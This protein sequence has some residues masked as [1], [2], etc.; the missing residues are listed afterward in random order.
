ME[1]AVTLVAPPGQPQNFALS[2]TPGSLD[3]S[4][5]WDAVGGASSYKLRWRESGGSFESG[6]AATVTGTSAAITA[7]GY[8]SWQVRVQGCNEAGCGPE[9]GGTV[10]VVP[11]PLNLPQNFA[12]SVE[13]GE[14]NLSARWDEVEGTTFYRLRWRQAGGEFTD[15][16]TTT[17]TDTEA[18][19]TVSTYGEWEVRLQACNQAGCVPE[20]DGA[21]DEAPEVRLKLE[22]VRESQGQSRASA[23]AETSDIGPADSKTSYTVGWHRTE[24]DAPAQSQPDAARQARAAGGTSGA[25]SQGANG[26][27]DTTPPVLLRGEIDGDTTTV[28]FSEDLDENYRGGHFRMTVSHGNGWVNF[29]VTPS[30]VSI[31]GN[32]VT[33][34][35]VL[36][37]GP[38]IDRV[39]A[40]RGVKV[41]YYTHDTYASNDR[42]LRDLAGN[43]V[44]TPHRS[45]SGAFP[46]TRTIRLRN[47]TQPPALQR[48]TAHL[49]RLTLTFD[50][51]LDRNSVPAADAFT[52]TVNGSEVSLAS[53]EPVSVSGSTVTLFL[54][55]A[56]ASTDAVTVSYTKPS[57][58]PLRGVDGAVRS[59]SSYPTNLVGVTPSVSGV[60]LTSDAGDDDTYA[61]GDTIRVTLTFSEAV[62]VDTT[63]GTPR[64][65]IKMAP[66]SGEKWADY[67]GGS[68]TTT[69]TFD[70]T[71]VKGDIS[72]D[73]V[74]VLT[75]TLELNGGTI[76]STASRTDALLGHVGLAHNSDHMVD[77]QQGAPGVTGIAI[78]SDP[79]DDDTYALGDTIQV[80]ATF[81]EAM[82]VDTTGGTPRLKIKM[83]PTSGEK[84][85]DYS[86]GSGTTTLT[87]DYT[88][89]KPNT[90]TGGIAVLAN[91]LELNGG[92]IRSTA[93]QTDARLGHVGL[94]HNADHKVDWQQGLPVSPVWRSPLTRVMTTATHSA[95]PSR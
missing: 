34:V 50:E 43:V 52:V 31:E 90:S 65:K 38:R 25:T 49:D 42:W 67:S 11:A 22:S 28:Y 60:E 94:A 40:G 87:F 66:T 76:R 26:A 12:V 59:F 7:S 89:V 9:T 85:A 61:L 79:G 41:Y 71:V 18:T 68:G 88:V 51:K 2:A 3:I 32:K 57:H 86:G 91:T 84:W 74:A 19:F 39:P 82:D 33:L 56:L 54:A 55:A 16:N 45:P 15:A 95:I 62:D 23:L 83:T 53:V 63:G 93:T 29:T 14:L 58:N 78:S 72:T 48:A 92:T 80:T 75:N 20:A 21:A 24:A 81:S 46:T 30:S 77:W 44:S 4:A 27:T 17:V 70:Y 1:R 35:G 6:N 47:L 36:D 37:W 8:G 5:T 73:G 69:L 10:E 64:L 13:Q